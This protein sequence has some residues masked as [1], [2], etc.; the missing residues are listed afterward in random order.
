MYENMHACMYLSTYT[1][2]HAL[3]HTQTKYLSKLCVNSGETV[4]YE[5]HLTSPAP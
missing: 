1:Q 2:T 3:K 5:P 4:G